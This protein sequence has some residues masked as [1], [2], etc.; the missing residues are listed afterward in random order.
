MLCIDC[1]E[2]CLR[3]HF[4]ATFSTPLTCCLCEH[5]FWYQA[6]ILVNRQPKSLKISLIWTFTSRY[7]LPTVLHAYG[8]ITLVL[9]YW[10]L[11]HFLS[12]NMWTM[13]IHWRKTQSRRKSHYNGKKDLPC[14]MK[15]VLYLQMWHL[16]KVHCL[17]HI[18]TGG[19]R[20]RRN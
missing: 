14:T 15:S 10:L 1:S 17:A 3:F 7:K 6:D 13:E 19:T 2:K 9:V 12:L 4:Y 18:K 5:D 16:L 11:N 20:V 8:K